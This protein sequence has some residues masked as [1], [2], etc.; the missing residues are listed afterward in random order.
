MRSAKSFLREVRNEQ[1]EVARLGLK[2]E[3]LKKSILPGGIRYD[4]TK[5]QRSP[6]D[7][8]TELMA[9]IGDVEM[10]L[11]DDIRK[12]VKDIH[13]ARQMIR[14]LGSSIQRDVLTRYYLPDI[15]PEDELPTWRD[16]AIS[17]H[18]SEHR[19][20]HIHGEA[21]Q[22]LNDKYKKISIK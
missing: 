6:D 17:M 18:Y 9:E 3:Y 12:L 14:G 2:L 4:V 7:K 22:Q 15:D 1:R 10:E 5:I 13:T 19:I 21:L 16:I 11:E 20:L 8:I